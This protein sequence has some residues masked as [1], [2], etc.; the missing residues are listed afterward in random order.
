VTDLLFVGEQDGIPEREF[1]GRIHDY[2]AQRNVLCRAYL[3]QVIYPLE[4]KSAVALCFGGLTQA[5]DVESAM[6]A[7][8][9]DMFRPEDFLDFIRVSK[10]QEEE[11]VRVAAP[12]YAG[13][14]R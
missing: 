14:C 7:I 5:D 1:K 6:E 10:E 9:A 12:F 13:R 4:K 2:L 3:A 11:L 8:F